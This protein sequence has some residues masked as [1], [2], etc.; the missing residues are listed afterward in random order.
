MRTS[1]QEKVM[2]N[3]LVLVLATI[4]TLASAAAISTSA[5]A[6]GGHGGL[7]GNGGHGTYGHPGHY[8]G[9][10]WGGPYRP[11]HVHFRRF[12]FGG[13]YRYYFRPVADVEP[14]TSAGPCTC[15]TKQYTPE[16]AVLFKDICTN[17]AAMNPPLQAVAPQQT[18]MYQAQ[19]SQML[20]QQSIPQAQ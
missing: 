5:F 2:S 19:P 15:L 1:T 20:P 11:H 13:R 6:A 7:G 4:T 12:Y 10:H 9:G 18:G 17:E 14:V 8:P 3:K 16:G